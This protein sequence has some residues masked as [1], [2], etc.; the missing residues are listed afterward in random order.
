MKLAVCSIAF[1]ALLSACAS[2]PKETA[3]MSYVGQ[4]TGFESMSCR[5]ITAELT[6]TQKAYARLT[7]RREAPPAGEPIASLYA[8]IS[9]T[10]ATPSQASRLRER[11]ADLQKVSRAKRCSSSGPKTATA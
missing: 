1:A 7:G 2:A 3:V 9:Y 4:Q 8:P 10:K 6:S 11:L 5:Q